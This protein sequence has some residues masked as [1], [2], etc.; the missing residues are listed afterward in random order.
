MR[1]MYRILAF[2]LVV[3]WTIPAFA[4]EP[5]EMLDDPVLEERARQISQKLR[6]LVC[7]NETIDES[8][9]DLARD[10]RVLVRERL[11]AGA[12]DEEVIDYVVARYGDFVLLSP[13]FKPSTF[14]LWIF[15]AL[16]LAV[17]AGLLVYLRKQFTNAES[18]QND[19]ELTAEEVQILDGILDDS[20][21]SSR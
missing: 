7:Q 10:L 19:V 15:P 4:V 8:N 11:A 17:G 18:E 14:L 12:T 9:A 2:I 13:P 6:C 21:K 16:A 3:V 1:K 20:K 5:S